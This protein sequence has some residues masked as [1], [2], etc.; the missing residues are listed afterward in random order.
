MSGHAWAAFYHTDLQGVWALWAVPLACLV[1]LAVVRPDPGRALDPMRTSFMWR[2]ALVFSIETMLD[3]LLG[4]PVVRALG[5]ADT[6]VATTV[7]VLFVLLGDFRVFLLV[8]ALVMPARPLDRQGVL[9]AAAEAARWT[10]LVPLVTLAVHRTLDALLGP[11]PAQ[12]IWLVYELAF[13]TLAVVLRARLL[14]AWLGHGQEAL[15][16]YLRAVLA[17][18]ALY[19][20]LWAGADILILGGVDAG[21]LVR[22]VPNQLYYALWVPTAYLLFFSP[23]YAAMSSSTQTSR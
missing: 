7:M 12:S 17:Y 6:W 23:R 1:Y 10:L 19:Y 13:L 15:H 8:F 21:W 14:P 16:A 11:L 20:A 18:V 22:I 3:P 5:L 2:Y 4:G 9:A